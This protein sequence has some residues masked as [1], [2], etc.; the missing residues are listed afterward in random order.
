MVLIVGA[1]LHVHIPKSKVFQQINIFFSGGQS[2]EVRWYLLLGCG[3]RLFDA[4]K[5]VYYFFG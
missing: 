4:F 2:Q 1:F 5:S 3:D